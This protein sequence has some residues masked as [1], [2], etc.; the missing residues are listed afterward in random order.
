MRYTLRKQEK[1][2][3]VFGDDYLKNHI[4]K[5]LDKYFSKQKDEEIIN[6]IESEDAY[7]D[8][9]RQISYP[10]LRIN[11]LANDNAMLEFAIIGLQYD[12]LRLT[13]LGR[14]KG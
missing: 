10:V 13:F 4:I 11:D 5:S 7:T 9:A 12:V 3:S 2:A 1:I 6:S 8:E 14:I